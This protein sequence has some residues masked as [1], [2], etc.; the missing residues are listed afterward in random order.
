MLNVKTSIE[1]FGIQFKGQ[2]DNFI[3]GEWVAPVN[4]EYFDNSTPI[5]KEVF[6]RVAR[7]TKE[8]V[9]LALDAAHEAQKLGENTR[10][11]TGTNLTSHC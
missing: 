2:Y 4:G 5:T 1:E 6:T 11:R 7:S 10:S 3:G 8:D 9:E